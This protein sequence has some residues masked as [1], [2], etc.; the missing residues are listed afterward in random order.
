LDWELTKLDEDGIDFQL[1]FSNP[2]LVSSSAIKDDL[3][4]EF[5]EPQIFINLDRLV[6]LKPDYIFYS[7]VPAQMSSE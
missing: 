1:N 5:L 7:K 2:I 6:S 4:I 3:S